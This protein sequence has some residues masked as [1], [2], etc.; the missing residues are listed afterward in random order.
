MKIALVAHGHHP[1][2]E[3]YAGGLEMHTHLLATRLVALGHEVVLY[4]KEGSCAE[5]YEVRAILPA[6]PSFI[7]HEVW[8]EAWRLQQS[9]IRRAYG[10]AV[11]SIVN[12]D[13]DFVINN[14]LNPAPIDAIHH[15]PVLTIL[16]TPRL[17]WMT[18]AVRRGSK[19]SNQVFASVSHANLRSWRPYAPH[20]A[21]VHN[22]IDIARWTSAVERTDSAAWVGRITPEKGLHLAIDA[23]RLAGRILRFAGPISDTRYFTERIKPQLGEGVEYV[24]HLKHSQLPDFLSAAAV[25][26]ASPLW[27]EP[28]GLTVTEALACG[29]PVAATPRGSMPEI[30]TNDVGCVAPKGTAVSLA[31]AIS[32][33]AGRQSEMC[34]A[35]VARKYTAP[36]MVAGYLALIDQSKSVEAPVPE[37]GAWQPA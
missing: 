1:I 16:H 3:P 11:D 7:P 17:G 35:L 28:F 23:S 20:A 5:D 6:H 25:F 15:V 10:G 13:F 18:S 29:T 21:V 36:R 31:I 27:D 24:G 32:T 22:G 30:V 2:A 19:M 9:R 14:S 34:R 8:S 33:A 12:R 26:V 4:A 37:A